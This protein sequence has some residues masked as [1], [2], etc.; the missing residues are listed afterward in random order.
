MDAT[1]VVSTCN[2]IMTEFVRL[3]YTTDPTEVQK[4]IS[5]IV[6]R[7]VPII[8]EFGGDIKVLSPNLTIP[9]KILVILYKKYPDYV[10]TSDLK[11]C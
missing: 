5:S 7:R 9:D 1:F 3:Y 8:E 4:I 6:E 11:K 10:S 2:W